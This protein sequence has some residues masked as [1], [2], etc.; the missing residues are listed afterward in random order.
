MTIRLGPRGLDAFVRYPGDP[1]KKPMWPCGGHWKDTL[2]LG[3][4]VSWV[5][6]YSPEKK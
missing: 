5:S 4:V 2:L 3:L 6:P 1:W